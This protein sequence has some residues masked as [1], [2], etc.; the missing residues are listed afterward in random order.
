MEYYGALY[1]SLLYVFSTIV[2]LITLL[3]GVISDLLGHKLMIILVP[4]IAIIANTTL[5]INVSLMSL[6]NVSIALHLTP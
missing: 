1:L 3:S 5:L 4:L 6:L 2:G